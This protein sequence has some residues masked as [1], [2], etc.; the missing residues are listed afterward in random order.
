MDRSLARAFWGCGDNQIIEFAMMRA[1]LNRN[2]SEVLRLLLDEC[3]TQEEAAEIMD[4]STRRLQEFWYSATD[5]L[6]RIPWVAAYA[7]ELKKE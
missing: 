2:E 1:R 4:I 6:L 3:K 7:R 5:K